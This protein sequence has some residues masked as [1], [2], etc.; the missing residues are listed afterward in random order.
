MTEFYNI[1]T[2]LSKK[3]VYHKVSLHC[4]VKN[5]QILKREIWDCDL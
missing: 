2:W 4:R 1:G 5:K 3:M